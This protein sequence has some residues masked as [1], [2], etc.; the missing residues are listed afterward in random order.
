MAQIMLTKKKYP[1]P[2]LFC[3]IV[4]LRSPDCLSM[5]TLRKAEIDLSNNA[6]L[7]MHQDPEGYMWFGT[8]DGLN[9]YNGK[10]NYIYRYDPDNPNSINGNIVQKITDAGNGYLWIST[11]MGVNRF[12]LK[13]RKFTA[14]YTQ[15][16][17]ARLL[18]ADKDGNT[19]LMASDHILSYY[20]PGSNR[21]QD[22]YTSGITLSDIKELFADT[23]GRFH[24]VTANGM[25]KQIEFL[26][27]NSFSPA[28][29]KF[30]DIAMHD[31]P[32]IRAY[33]EEEKIYFIDESDNL[34]FYNC[35]SKQKE[36]V[37]NLT[38]LLNQFGEISR[39][40]AWK[41]E[42]YIAFNNN[43]LIRLSAPVETIL[44]DTRIF[45][46]LKD[47][48]QDILWIGTDGQGVEMYYSEQEMFG[49]IMLEEL[50]HLNRK[51]IRTLYTDEYGNLWIGTKGDGI[52]RINDYD[53]KKTTAS[54]GRSSL[55]TT[56][57]GLSDNQVFCFL[58][59]RYNKDIL[60]IGT[61]GPGLSYYSYKK[62]RIETLP[63][64][65]GHEIGLVHSICEINDSTL[66]IATAGKGLMKVMLRKDNGEY[67]IKKRDVYTFQKSGRICDEFHS[68]SYDGD[69]TLLI[70]SRGGYGVIRFNIT[71]KEYDFLPLMQGASAAIGDVLCVCPGSDPVYYFGASS[72][73]TQ[74]KY[75]PDEEIQVKHFSKKDGLSNDMIHGILEDA[76][77]CFWL[78]TNKGLTKYNPH[79]NFFHNYG[80][81]DLRVIEFSDDAYW[82][83]PYTG[84]LFF[85]GIN[86]LVWIETTE[87]SRDMYSPELHFWELTM[88]SR[89]SSLAGSSSPL[90]IPAGI[91]LFT[92]SFVATDYINGENYEYSYLLEGYT[93]QWIELQKRN[94]VE[95][96]N[97]PPGNYTLHVKYKND[98]FDAITT[99]NR[100]ALLVKR[101]WYSTWQAYIIYIAI[102]LSFGFVFLRKVQKRLQI[103]RQMII[104]EQKS[105]LYEAK[106]NFF[107]QI[108]H[109]LCTPL[110]LIRGISEQIKEY[111]VDIPDCDFSKYTDILNRNVNELNEL[112]LEILD[113]RKQEDTGAYPKAIHRTDVSQLIRLQYESFTLFA[114]KDNIRYSLS[115]PET[116]YWNTDPSYLRKILSNILSNAFK[117]TK[118]GETIRITGDIRNQSL[119]ISVYNSGEGIEESKIDTL[120]DRYSL[121]EQIE[122]NKY[123]QMSA[124]TGLGLAI[125]KN[126]TELLEGT[127]SI[128]SETGKF[129]EVIVTLPYLKADA[130]QGSPASG[131]TAKEIVSVNNG[132]SRPKILIVDD[133]KDILWFISNTLSAEYDILEAHD[134]VEAVRIIKTQTPSLIIT[135]IMMPQMDGF[136]FIQE[137]KKDKF[138]RHIP[139]IIVSAKIT[140]NEKAQ[141]LDLGAD[142]Y[143]TKP[144]SP[145]LLSSTIKRLISN[146]KEWKEYYNSPESVYEVNE[147]QLLHQEDKE[148]LDNVTQFIRENIGNED[149]RPELIAEHLHLSTRNLYR[150][151]KKVSSLPPRE[152]IKE[153]KFIY[154]AQLL[155]DTHLSIQEIIY[156]VGINNK[157]YFYREFAGKFG[158]TPKEYRSVNPA[159]TE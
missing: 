105:K 130:E 152:F 59:S 75:T 64:P 122:E 58:R 81:R 100:I 11:F 25:L 60:W 73:L 69:Q 2:L 133:N 93:D 54:A 114:E 135:D 12:C 104:Q 33:Y 48:R 18:C 91:S 5:E 111:A 55:Y 123:I 79:N 102:L 101:P 47:N 139:L 113:F 44:P 85:G 87:N 124:R 126:L 151:F 106:I 62:D 150:R 16:P 74:M 154:A 153:Y 40:Q 65:P 146:K 39:I 147:G 145:V 29:I 131:N 7:C 45:S 51:P 120:F 89:T 140:D 143:I 96:F 49:S 71:S 158:M 82:K 52:L 119:V 46:L 70:G 97:L 144:F 32:I 156:K 10:D 118:E 127:I 22:M 109:E 26:A 3:L 134:G 31:R 28:G 157:S 61:E 155:R 42:I 129:V 57:N 37:S 1:I 17:E 24:L 67:S 19:L 21:F 88:N 6:I 137:I 35:L 116:L 78:S 92:V 141:G 30:H 43:G 23:N 121:L 15:Y 132:D 115:I 125:C 128:Q 36:F 66:W 20:T 4:F 84:R 110:T 27:G 38:S 95:F 99:G 68:M 50:P 13:E 41:G 8:Y 142:A 108:T 103:K 98:V 76:K 138:T 9:L 14:S 53:R 149:L 107:T 117:Y 56:S 90:V 72:G 112:I 94:K 63:S 34:Y 77:G 148:F 80:P 136:E 86:G 83:C 159:D